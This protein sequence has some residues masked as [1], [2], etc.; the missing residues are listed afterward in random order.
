[1]TVQ[2]EAGEATLVEAVVSRARD[3]A[4][5]LD[6]GLLHEEFVRRYYDRVPE[7]ELAARD[8]A[9]LCGAALAHLEL[10]SGRRGPGS[11]LRVY[12]PEP[13]RDGWRSPHTAVEI[14]SDDMPFL[15]DSVTMELDRRGHAV[16]S[17]IHP[18][19]AVHRDASGAV[20][21]FGPLGAP[22]AR[23][24]SVIHV[25]IAREPD[26]GRLR[27]LEHGLRHVLDD[28]AAAVAD[29]PAMLGRMEE[30]IADLGR[31][32]GADGAVEA[33]AF[34]RWLADD[35]FVFLGSRDY[36]LVREDD[37]DHLRAQGGSGLGILRGRGD[38][39]SPS[40]AQVP[41]PVRERARSP[42]PLVLTK[43]N[44]RSTVHRPLYLDYVGVKR[45]DAAGGVVGERRFLGLYTT[46]AARVSPWSIP[47]VRGKV[48][49][50]LRRAA[51][52]PGGHDA[53]ALESV[54]EGY[55]RDELFQID[56]DSLFDIAMGIVALG[57]R[58]RVRLFV[59]HDPFGRFVSCLVFVPRDRFTTDIRRGIAAVLGDELR[60]GGLDWAV[61]HS[62]SVHVRLLLT[63]HLSD[64]SPAEVDAQSLEDR[65]LAVVRS[66]EDDL[67]EALA[68]AHGEE[69]GEVL[70]RRYRSAFPLTYR[71]D[72]SAATAVEDIEVL[73]GLGRDGVDITVHRPSGAADVPLRCRIFSAGAPVLLSEV[74]PI[75]ENLG[76]RVADERP[77]EVRRGD[78]PTVWL[79]DIGLACDWG[80]DAEVEGFTDAFLGVWR[81]ELEDDR[82]SGLVTSAGLTGRQVSVLR[83]AVKY[84]RQAGT[85]F[86][87]SYLQQALMSHPGIARMLV[88]L[89]EARLHPE[90]H[91]AAVAER[92]VEEI[93]RGIDVVE[94]LDEDRLLRGHLAFVEAIV[95]T[96]YFREGRGYLSFK[97]DPEQ[98]P[99]LPAPRPRHEIFVYSPRMEGVHLRGGRVAR[100]GLRWSDRREDFRLEVLG[101]M[102][103]QMVKNAL[104]VPVGAKG[105]FVVKRPPRRGD[106]EALVTEAKACYET[107]IRGMLDVTDNVVDGEVVA[108]RDVVRHDGDDPY[109]VVA[110]DKGT[111]TLSDFANE[112]AREYGFWLGDAFASGGEHGYDHKRMG[113]TARGAWESVR[114]HFREIG[115]DTQASDF[116]VVGIGDMA[117]DVFGNGMLLSPHIKLVGAFNHEH[118]FLDPDPDPARSFEER[119]RLFE[120]PRP[121]WLDYDH[122]LISQG[123]GVF[124]RAA[125]RV[126]LSPEARAALAVEAASLTPD[127]L[128]RA[129]LRAPVDL[130]WNGGIGTFVKASWETDGDVGDKANDALRVTGNALRCRV[131]GEG[132]N[133]GLTQLGRIEYALGGGR[134]YTD[135]IDNVAG[136]NCSDQEVNLKILLDAEVAEGGM[137]TEERNQLLHDLTDVVAGRVTA[138]SYAQTLALGLERARAPRLVDLH[139]GLVR[140]LE[141]VAGLDRELE[142]LPGDEEIAERKRAG[143]GL[144]APEL[145]LLFAYTKNMLH[146][147]LLSSDV[148]EDDHLTDEIAASFPSPLPERFRGQMRRHPL[149]GD[150]IATYL[151]NEIVDRGGVTFAFRIAE[152]NEAG[153]SDL[154]RAY[155]VALAA[156]DLRRFWSDVRSLD[157]R[158]DAAVQYGML[159]DARRLLGRATRWLVADPRRP[160]D[161]PTVTARVRPAVE[162]VAAGLPDL[163]DGPTREAW[164]ARHDELTSAGVPETLAI[165]AASTGPLFFALNIG[166][167]AGLVERP[168]DDVAGAYFGLAGRLRLDW[169]A[170]RILELPRSDRLETLARAGLRDDAYT[171]HR[172]LTVE[173]LR[174]GTL[175]GWLEEHREGVEWCG[176]VLADVQAGGVHDVTRLSAAMRAVRMLIPP[177]PA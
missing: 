63:V 95:R 73:E 2:P 98:L 140:E 75:F 108:P 136:V 175:D 39:L 86:S 90:R 130:V 59:R 170:D 37:E 97:L 113:I 176:K 30:A 89:F 25:E 137:R 121:S 74:L 8:P 106:R 69:R 31:R 177:A 32:S 67:A 156:F 21:G 172:Q 54:L 56:E 24:E 120:S 115:L 60:A 143:Q 42:E 35:Q 141:Q 87:D 5:D 45:F 166:D 61:L 129:L 135:A 20:H 160:I 103:A 119:K 18:V 91:D 43:G 6:T 53:K 100:G 132:G 19:M 154:A 122:E 83:A 161:I 152:E 9:H 164:D 159:F 58:Q 112:I 138:Q 165:R 82:L 155:A 55:P 10:L 146:A 99:F 104:I 149:R 34:L 52:P 142:F 123:G 49:G 169:L 3:H 79:Y 68:E 70:A 4:R 1:L 162:A 163:L 101:L 22:N 150:I 157:D 80:P 131:V 174:S 29:W 40:F 66:W 126:D 47:V 77:H 124:E 127:E 78:A 85:T 84:R 16:E 153:A 88:E 94:S 111:A 133:L 57:Q 14:V 27:D 64:D 13:D 148:T 158:V 167:A 81:G 109:L 12:N 171:A 125:K 117:G 118:V 36:E 102:K 26:A 28:V 173:V 71:A 139:A 144:T 33:G 44:R 46:R 15:V 110:A 105:G 134:L 51:L 23:S 168:L 76:A 128:I 17:L 147:A 62:E 38:A 107:L 96:N 114:R 151:A 11:A 7:E 116:T 48:Q 50:V 72:C 145:A 41:G 93:G 65:L 92:L